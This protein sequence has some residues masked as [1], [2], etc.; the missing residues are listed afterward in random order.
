MD[1][2]GKSEKYCKP[3]RGHPQGDVPTIDES[4]CE[5]C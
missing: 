2:A 5:A 3:P 4:A 1:S